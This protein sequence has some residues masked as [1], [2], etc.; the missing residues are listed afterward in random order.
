M[1]SS[2]RLETERLVLRTPHLGDAPAIARSYGAD[3]EVTRYLSWRPHRKLDDT[4]TFLRDLLRRQRAGESLA[5]VLT[6]RESSRLLGMIEA[7]PRDGGAWELG[8]VLA[9]PHWGAGLMPEAVEAVVGA[10]REQG[11]ERIEALTDPD[12]AASRRC[13]EKAGFREDGRVEADEV[14]PNL[15]PEPRPSLRFVREG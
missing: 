1:K 14:R 5:W 10:L 9:R 4:T 11:A 12:N 3:E 7:N 8:Y 13:L 6:D 2:P 15:S